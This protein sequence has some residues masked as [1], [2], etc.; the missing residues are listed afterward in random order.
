MEPFITTK[1]IN[2]LDNEISYQPAHT[3]V[4]QLK[5]EN[6]PKPNFQVTLSLEVTST[7]S[8]KSGLAQIMLTKDD[9]VA[10]IKKLV[11]NL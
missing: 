8:K 5:V 4:A 1:T 2:Y 3:D 10:L 9:Q 6:S 11:D 7:I